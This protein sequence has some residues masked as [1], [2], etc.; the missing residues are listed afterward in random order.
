V[1]G[2]P[3]RRVHGRGLAGA[4]SRV[5]AHAESGGGGAGSDP[6]ASSPGGPPPLPHTDGRRPSARP[7]PSPVATLS[8]SQLAANAHL[9][10]RLRGAVILAPLTRVGTLPFRALCADF[11]APVTVSEMAFARPLARGDRVERARLRRAPGERLYGF[12]FTTNNVGEGLA[13]ARAAAEAG[14]DFVDLNAGCPIHEATRRGLGA[15]LLRNTR[16]LATLVSG[17]AA[18]SPLPLT[19]K[20]RTGLSANNINVDATV[21]ALADAGAAAVTVHGRTQEQRYKRAADWGAISRVAAAHPAL[22]LIGNGDVLT[23]WEVE[24]R[25]ASTPVAGLMVGRG[26]LEKPWLWKEIADGATWLP[27]DEERLGVLHAFMGRM[28]I[29]WATMPR[30]GRRRNTS[31]LPTLTFSPGGGRCQTA[32][33]GRAGLIS[34]RPP[35]CSTGGGRW[36]TRSWARRWP[37][38]RPWSASCAAL[39]RARTLPWP[40]P[41]GRRAPRRTRCG[42]PTQLPGKAW[43]AGRRRPGRRTERRKTRVVMMRERGGGMGGVGGVMTAWRAA[44]HQDLNPIPMVS[45]L[46]NA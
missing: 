29:T 19:V 31:C 21:A 46:A 11:G 34:T 30:A 40:P 20:I 44:R 13:A 10:S 35:P 12:Q 1:H 26:A 6:T 43:R 15:A 36:P 18:E 3:V 5:M 39:M 17:I 16:K 33:T 38:S 22:A 8:P 7:R 2:L 37:R 32:C 23:H 42:P 45:M 24:A 28:R 41:C 4:G 9:A 14:C 25:L 27:T